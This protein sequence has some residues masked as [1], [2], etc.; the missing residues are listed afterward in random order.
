MLPTEFNSQ[1]SFL[2]L[3]FSA[4]SIRT[5]VEGY[6]RKKKRKILIKIIDYIIEAG[7]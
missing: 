5:S 7:W 4:N 6:R 1:F 3:Q 2:T